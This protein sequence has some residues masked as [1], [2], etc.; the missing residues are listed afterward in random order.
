MLRFELADLNTGKVP[1]ITLD[2]A[3]AKSASGEDF[4]QTNWALAD[5]S[6]RDRVRPVLLLYFE[7]LAFR[8][9]APLQLEHLPYTDTVSKFPR[10]N[11]AAVA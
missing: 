9:G 2:F 3:S 11:A 5:F 10:R 7:S 4:S 6:H 1:E 8:Q